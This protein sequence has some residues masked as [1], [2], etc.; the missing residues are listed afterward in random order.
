MASTYLSLHYHLVFG[1]KSREP[2]I[3]AEWR[4][5]L[6]EYLGGTISG[7]GGFPQGVGGVADHVHLLVNYPPGGMTL[8]LVHKVIDDQVGEARCAVL[9][10]KPRSAIDC[11]YVFRRT[12]RWI[13]FPWSTDEPVWQP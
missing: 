2:F 9:Y 12:D 3:A 1:T 6:H 13:N 4:S 5:R 10:Q 7:L 11:E 8:Q